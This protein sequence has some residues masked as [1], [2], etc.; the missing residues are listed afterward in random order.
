MNSVNSKKDL[1]EFIFSDGVIVLSVDEEELAIDILGKLRID[2]RLDLHNVLDIID[3]ETKLL[4]KE[5]RKLYK[6]GAISYVGRTSKTRKIAR[7]D[8]MDRIDIGQ[9]DYG[10]LVFKRGRKDSKNTFTEAGSKA[11]VNRYL[12]HDPG[13]LTLFIDD[14]EDHIESTKYFLGQ[15]NYYEFIKPLLFESGREE[16]LLD[17]IG[18][19]ISM[20]N[21]KPNKSKTLLL[22]NLV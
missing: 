22:T 8:I 10:I 17:L 19:Y 21:S 3:D 5:D 4:G 1:I 12:Y 7:D 11:W 13:I 14:A 2:I 20:N 18:E 6:I 9:I 16:D 15:N